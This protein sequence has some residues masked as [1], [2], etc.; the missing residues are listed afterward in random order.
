MDVLLVILLTIIIIALIGALVIYLRRKANLKGKDVLNTESIAPFTSEVLEQERVQ[1][2]EII[3]P[4]EKLP[5]TTEIDENSLFEI[6]DPTVI[7]RISETI[8][9]TVDI[10]ARTLINTASNT[11]LKN[12]NTAADL[13]IQNATEIFQKGDIYRAVIPSGATLSKSAQME[14]AVRGFYHGTEGIKGQANLVKVEAPQLVKVDP[15]KI[16]KATTVANGVANVMNVGSLVVGQY[17]MSEINSKLE[18]MNKNINKAIDFQ[19]REFKSR[20]LSLVSRVGEISQFSSEIMENDELRNIKFT[21]LENLKGIATELLGQ[22]NL[23]IADTYSK[24]SNPSFKE[25]QKIIDDF[26]VLVEYQN[27]LVASLEEIC[28]LTYILAKGGI[29]VEISYSLFNKFLD[30]S[31]QTRNALKQWHDRQVKSLS[32]DLDKNRISKTGVEGFFSAIPGFV[33]DKW[34]YKELK[35]G[36]GQKIDTQIKHQPKAIDKAEEVYDK[37]IQIII[38]EG[39]YYYLH[40]F[41][42]TGE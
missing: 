4:I 18:T 31:I 9:A 40:D 23:T 39:K 36:L 24:S 14:G 8:P 19:D 17:Y 16:S 41:S 29:S 28:K 21:A 33:D 5:V 25:Y 38:K 7:A 15:T 32:I 22:V 42:D 37:D 20:I 6:T 13:A 10:A 1:E 30:Q 26:S 35:Q 3:I 34:K 27:A 11:A 2:S 12:A